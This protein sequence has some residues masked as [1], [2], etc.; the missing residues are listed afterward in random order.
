MKDKTI[1]FRVSAEEY[2]KIYD[3]ADKEGCTVSKFI[4]DRVINQNQW[5]TPK[6]MIHLENI[7]SIINEAAVA[8]GDERKGSFNR[9]VDELWQ[10]LN[11]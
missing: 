2:E 11:W 7:R 3:M 10:L 8:I 4:T 1:H 6:V 9:E 5:Y